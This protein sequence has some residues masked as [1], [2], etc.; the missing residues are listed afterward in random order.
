MAK[1]NAI[2]QSEHSECGLAAAAC[3]LQYHHVPVTL[4]D[5]R[6]KYG[7]PKGGLTLQNIKMILED[8]GV[9]YK[10]IRV[11]DPGCLKDQRE[12]SIVFWDD[13]HFVVLYRV[14]L[15]R[16]FVMDPKM[17]K[18]SY[19]EKEFY[20]HF[21][22][23][24][25]VINE[26]REAKASKKKLHDRT[27]G[28]GIFRQFLILAKNTKMTIIGI[29]AVMFLL[30]ML[31]LVVPVATQFVV[32]GNVAVDKV[33]VL[34]IVFLV[35]VIGVLYYL[36]S[37]CNGLLLTSLQLNWSKCLSENFYEKALSK[38]LQFYINRS[39]GSMIYK[40]SLISM[41][42]ATLSGSAI[43][44]AI[45]M[46]FLF[47]YIAFMLVA[48]VEL[49][50][51][52]LL[53]CAIVVF[54][55]LVY[56]KWNYSINSRVMEA[57]SDVQQL[58][59]ELFS[60]IETVKSLGEEPHFLLKWMER[61]RKSLDGLKEQGKITAW[62]SSISGTLIFILPITVL[63]F[64]VREIQMG[65][66]TLGLVVAF[67][68]LSSYLSDPF[69]K[70]IGS[71]SQFMLLKSYLNQVAD[72]TEERG[73]LEDISGTK[74]MR[75]VGEIELENVAF[76]FSR[77]DR[78]VVC[79][80]NLRIKKGEKVAIVGRSGSGKST[81]LKLISGLISPT[82]GT[83]AIDGTAVSRYDKGSL[84]NMICFVPQDPIVFGDTLLENLMLDGADISHKSRIEVL[85][86]S[87][88]SG[89]AKEMN[90]GFHSIISEN[91]MNI[92]GGQ[93][94]RIAIARSL[95]K[96]PSVIIMDEP[97]SS[98]DGLSEK[99]II[100]YIAQCERTVIIAAHRL[101]TVKK[102]DR[103]IVLEDGAVVEEG[104]H[105]QLLLRNGLYCD[106]YNESSERGDN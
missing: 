73:L 8:E 57:Q 3:V 33:S 34:R 51:I 98:L 100:D 103:I 29:V 97:T 54:S 38:K 78:Y 12:P 104:T 30:K 82:S 44:N 47:V 39:S 99:K 31:T 68:T 88:V 26:V 60:G 6:D 105:E 5:L 41:I 49:T 48:S 59:V 95:L 42:Q 19:S 56:A 90:A 28:K 35:C 106:L 94:Q 16:Y 80:M 40:S 85:E 45:D 87:G 71:V 22:R 43:Q 83:I 58:S 50:L 1:I 7:S 52:V 77:F 20:K 10:G 67:M 37:V 36:S 65:S 69:S 84:R 70:L 91:G 46:L 96:N 32:D 9:G 64:G 2:F 92:S 93:K 102:M 14:C 13:S 89:I 11:L 86:A 27:S 66:M 24:S 62:M 79:N 75:H 4:G 18:V 21:S 74:V 15:S 81:L 17:G 72:V 101:N 61:Y 25:L 23:Y 63:M 76:K 53:I 55:S